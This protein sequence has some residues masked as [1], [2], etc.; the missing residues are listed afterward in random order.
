MGTNWRDRSIADQREDSEG[1][2]EERREAD[3]RRRRR[4]REG[5]I[6]ERE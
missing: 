5:E 1:E 3:D 6:E 4:E 2:K